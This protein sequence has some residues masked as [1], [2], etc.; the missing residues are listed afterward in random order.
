[1]P[2]PSVSSCRN[3]ETSRSS[4]PLSHWSTTLAT[5]LAPV[6]LLV[7]CSTKLIMLC[8]ACVERQ[9]ERSRKRERDRE[10]YP[11]A[12]ATGGLSMCTGRTTESCPAIT[13]SPRQWLVSIPRGTECARSPHVPV[14]A[15]RVVQVVRRQDTMCL[16]CLHPMI[17]SQED[18]QRQNDEERQLHCSPFTGL[19]KVH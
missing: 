14:Y 8:F 5:V 1:M 6:A 16:L 11:E 18:D 4:P 15:L 19:V 2:P 10:R 17:G 7:T 12:A 9:W 3:T 13:L